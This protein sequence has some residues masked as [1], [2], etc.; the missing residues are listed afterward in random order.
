[1]PTH[2][3]LPEFWRDLAG[4]SPEQRRA[5]RSAVSRFAADLTRGWFRAGLRVKHVQGHQG[6][7]EMTWAPDGRATFQYGP[8][9][10][11][12]EPHVIWRRIGTHDIF[13]EP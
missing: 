3:E 4:L 10:M 5:F 13:R 11:P 6:V 9:I 2:E 7:W 12:G 1:M 8:E